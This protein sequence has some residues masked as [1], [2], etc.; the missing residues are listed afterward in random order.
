MSQSSRRRYGQREGGEG[1]KI[2]IGHIKTAEV[3]HSDGHLA[4]YI[5]NY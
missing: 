5:L 4:N 1:M 3:T 2:L